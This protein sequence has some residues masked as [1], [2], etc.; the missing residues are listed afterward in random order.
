M[1]KKCCFKPFIQKTG[2]LNSNTGKVG[3]IRNVWTREKSLA[4]RTSCLMSNRFKIARIFL[5]A[6][7]RYFLNMIYSALQTLFSRFI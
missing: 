1:R 3:Q 7:K 6:T 4:H 5:G 2:V